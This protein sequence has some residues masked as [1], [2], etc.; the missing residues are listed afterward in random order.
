MFFSLEFK[1]NFIINLMS[2]LYNE[3]ERE[4]IILLFS[5]NT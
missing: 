5:E 3:C 4:S 1:V 2:K